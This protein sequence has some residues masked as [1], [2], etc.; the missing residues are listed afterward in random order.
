MSGG[1]M[2]ERYRDAVFSL[3]VVVLCAVLLFLPTGFEERISSGVQH[4]RGLVLETDN[5]GVRQH[6]IVRTGTQDIRVRI[7]NGSW[8]GT[9]VEA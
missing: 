7:L 2:A 3:V 9:M 1:F 4:A 5:S 8:K 6:G